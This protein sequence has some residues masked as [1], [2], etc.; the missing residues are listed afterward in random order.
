MNPPIYTHLIF[1]KGAKNT[2]WRNDSLFNKRYWENW[3]A[4]CRKLKVDLCLSPW[5][6]V[7]TKWI[8]DLNISPETLK[9]VQERALKAIV[10]GNDFLSRTQLPQQLRER[11][12]KWDY[13]K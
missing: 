13:M 5:T 9:L 7:N 11:I 8:K 3:I 10:I 1:D 4:A 12:N 2:R 6:N